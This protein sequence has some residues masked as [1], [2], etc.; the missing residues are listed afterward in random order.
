[1]LTV[2]FTTLLQNHLARLNGS[3]KPM[4]KKIFLVDIDGTICE[5]IPN[6]AGC[7]AM[8]K[9]KPFPD[10]IK[11]VN[12]RHAEGNYICFFTA[13]RSDEHK[14]VTDE[15]LKKQGLKYDQVIYNK[16]RRTKELNQYHLIDNVSVRATKYEGKFTEFKKKNFDIEVFA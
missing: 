6:E 1:M 10:A 16:P 2:S 3:R 12:K 4:S 15:W 13:R 9:A 5:D 14:E 11:W 7:E 8:A